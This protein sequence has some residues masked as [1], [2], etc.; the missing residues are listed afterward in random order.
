M[1]ETGRVMGT[2]AVAALCL[3]AVGAQAEQEWLSAP[4]PAMFRNGAPGAQMLVREIDISLSDIATRGKLRASRNYDGFMKGR[5]I[6]SRRG[7]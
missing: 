1:G 3:W 6:R 5:R 7:R 2:M 4:W